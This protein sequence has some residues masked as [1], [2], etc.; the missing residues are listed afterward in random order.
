VIYYAALYPS[1][2]W[3][4]QLLI[5]DVL[6]YTSFD[7]VLG[8]FRINAGE[9]NMITRVMGYFRSS[10]VIFMKQ[11]IHMLSN[12][13][14]DFLAAQQRMLSSL[15]S[16]GNKMPLQDG[17]DIIFL[18]HPD[19]FYHLGEVIQDQITVQPVPISRKIQPIIEQIDWVRAEQWACSAG[20]G[21]YAYFALPLIG[22]GGANDCIVVYNRATREW[23][24][25]PDTWAHPQFRIQS[26]HTTLYDGARELFA[27]G[28]TPGASNIYLLY[29]GVE[30]EIAGTSFPVEDVMETR[31][32]TLGDPSAFKRIERVSV[33]LSTYDPEAQITAISDGQNEEKEL[34]IVTK[35]RRRSYLHGRGEFDPD[36][37]D[38]NMPRREDYSIIPALDFAGEDFELYADGPV[39]TLAGTTV[40]FSGEKQQSLER[41]QVR[42]NGRWVS[43]RIANTS[44]QCDVLSVGV[45]GFNTQETIK[46]IA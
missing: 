6:N 18:S 17:S 27:V 32:Y 11:S 38:E 45:E 7:N 26:L 25:A 37:D 31:G 44:G 4:D 2:P 29:K 8:I 14:L 36:T 46:V 5:S 9:S 1:L 30:D 24:S 41:F 22:K 34:S 19:G 28:D 12:F 23:E 40:S 43:I 33:G 20:L 35:D 15:G 39:T 21:D 3:R 42:Q 16:V 13:Q 10:L